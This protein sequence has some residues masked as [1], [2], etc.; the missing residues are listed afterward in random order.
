MCELKVL[1]PTSETRF[2]CSPSSVRRTRWPCAS[3]LQD[4]PAA[5]AASSILPRPRLYGAAWFFN[6]MSGS[7]A[8]SMA[9]WCGA[10]PTL[11]TSRT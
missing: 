4:T 11:L 8:Y 7:S 9:D 1:R 6:M 2:F 3:R 5:A 10:P